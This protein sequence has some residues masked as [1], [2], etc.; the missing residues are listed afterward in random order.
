MYRFNTNR[1]YNWP[2][3]ALIVVPIIDYTCTLQ[4][5]IPTG[6]LLINKTVGVVVNRLV[7]KGG[8]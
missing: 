5:V 3:V 6:D 4:S 2:I 8:V 7:A 1:H